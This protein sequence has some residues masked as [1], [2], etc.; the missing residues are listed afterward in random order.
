MQVKTPLALM[1]LTGLLRKNLSLS[2]LPSALSF[3]P[4]KVQSARAQEQMIQPSTCWECGP[5]P[6]VTAR[7]VAKTL[8][9]LFSFHKNA[10][11]VIYRVTSQGIQCESTRDATTRFESGH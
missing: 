7:P 1:Y 5:A 2:G 6:S 11:D 10:I 8:P 4:L 9:L 3:P